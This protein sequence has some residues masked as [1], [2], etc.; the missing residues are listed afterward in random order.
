L[1]SFMSRDRSSSLALVGL[2]VC[3]VMVASSS[4]KS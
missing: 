2:V 3:L 1:I 4:P